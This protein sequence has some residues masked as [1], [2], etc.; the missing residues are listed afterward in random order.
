MANSH[1]QPA[2]TWSG[3]PAWRAILRCGFI[4]A[5]LVWVSAGIATAASARFESAGTY[6]KDGTYYLDSFARLELGDAAEA[7]LANGVNLFFLVEVR[8]HRERKW[9]IDTPVLERRL[10]YKLYYYDLTL[11]YRVED[12]QTGASTNYRSLAAALR[13]LGKLDQF[14][15]IPQSRLRNG[16]RYSASIRLELDHTRLPGPLQA[17]ALVSREWQIESEEFRWLLN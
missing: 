1:N 10:R 5:M 2:A 13:K 14:A 6:L 16:R 17:Q 12:L 7:A 15:L 11:H 3:L 4:A 9:W 8:V